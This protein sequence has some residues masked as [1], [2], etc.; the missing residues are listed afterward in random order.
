M[1]P[2]G[3]I[4]GATALA[5]DKGSKYVKA[6]PRPPIFPFVN[7]LTGKGF[8]DVEGTLVFW[9]TRAD[10]DLGGGRGVGGGGLFGVVGIDEDLALGDFG[11]I[12]SLGSAGGSTAREFVG[13]TGSECVMLDIASPAV[14][15]FDDVV[16]ELFSCGGTRIPCLL[17]HRRLFGNGRPGSDIHGTCC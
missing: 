16:P 15:A 2:L 17:Y 8:R 11:D 9:L 3:R 1:R 13:V 12:S 7:L 5:G 14:E 6:A 10:Q 4:T